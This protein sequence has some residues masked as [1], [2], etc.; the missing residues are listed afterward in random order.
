M[1]VEIWSDIMCPFCYIGKRRF[2]AALQQFAHRSE[3]E[4]VWKS[5]ELDP[6]M[7]TKPGQSIHQLLA[8]RKGVSEAEGRKMNDYMAGVAREVGLEYD[9]ERMVP[10][11]TFNAHRFEH[12]AATKGKQDAAEERLFAAY[13]TEGKNLDDLDVLAQLGAEI[14]LDAAEVKQTLG[15]DAFVQEV[16]IDEYQARQIGVRGVPFFVFEDKYAVSGAQPA[17]L[18]QEVLEK[19]WD[20]FNPAPALTALATDGPACGPDGVC[21]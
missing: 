16:R 5:F 9:F 11:N 21:D 20:E 12:L 14:G 6:E 18:F 4:I 7:K 3:V 8:E 1:K 13:F 17:E 15:T 10:V 2:E 19:V